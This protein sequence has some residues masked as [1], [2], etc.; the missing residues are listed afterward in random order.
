MRSV[1]YISLICF[2]LPCLAQS[3]PAKHAAKALAGQGVL[4]QAL[5]QASAQQLRVVQGKILLSGKNPALSNGFVALERRELEHNVFTAIPLPRLENMKLG[6]VAPT[7]KQKEI[8]FTKYADLAEKTRAFKAEIDGLLYYQSR[9]S[10]RR[11]L[12]VQEKQYWLEKISALSRELN[13]LSL[14]VEETD[15]VFMRIKKYLRYALS[16]VA[17]EMEGA[18]LDLF[19]T[20]SRTDRVL[21]V[22]E[23]Y[24]HD[25]TANRFELWRNFFKKEN[26]TQ[27]VPK[28]LKIAVLND[29]QSFLWA[30]EESYQ[31]KLLFK[32]HYVKT[33]AH[34][35][36][37]LDDMRV[38]RETFDVILSDLHV[39]GGGGYHVVQTLR[40]RGYKG[41][42]IAAS[43]YPELTYMAQALYKR[44]FDG[45]FAIPEIFELNPHWYDRLNQGL[46]NYFYYR[47]TN[48][49]MR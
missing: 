41:V 40:A 48:G 4:E 27:L 44:G 9:P 2:A 46:R 19:P 47:H 22:E 33:Y 10:E 28:G 49:W 18:F 39:P 16:V 17:P 8:I 29:R 15:P 30:I 5:K 38:G 6:I 25:P 24:L 13:I 1:L 14:S 37:L 26:P 12:S 11:E 36:N 43:A 7:A 45:M 32:G 21:K 34:A 42:I 3:L 23:F 20:D 31:E 35:A